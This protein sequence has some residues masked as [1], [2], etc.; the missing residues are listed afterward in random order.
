MGLYSGG[1]L[2]ESVLLR[3][4]STSLSVPDRL[5]CPPFGSHGVTMEGLVGQNPG[6]DEGVRA[7]M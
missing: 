1:F 2:F 7:A 4:M 3:L 6:A 5:G